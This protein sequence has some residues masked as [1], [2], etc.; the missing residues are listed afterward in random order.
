[1]MSLL[2]L[3]LPH[4]HAA[5]DPLVVNAAGDVASS[6]KDNAVGIV[7]QA[8]LLV[9][10]VAIPALFFAVSWIVRKIFGRRK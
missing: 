9:A 1:M 3:L 2:T 6:V 5:A 10:I 8:D 4:A 7:T